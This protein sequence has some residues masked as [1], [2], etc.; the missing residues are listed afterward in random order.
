[1]S[2]QVASSVILIRPTGFGFDPQTAPSNP[3]QQHLADPEVERRAGDEFDGL[4]EALRTHGIDFVVLD[5]FDPEAP[6]GVFP[7]NWFSTHADGT[8]VL[9]PMLT[10]S[11][12][13]ERDPDL[14][15]RLQQEGFR[16][17]GTVDLS[18]WE[19]RGRILEGTGSLVLDRI[20]RKAYACISERTTETAVTDWCQRFGYTPITFVATED[21]RIPDGGGVRGLPVYHTNVVMSIG[22][23]FAV[24]CLDAMPFPAERQEVQE[25]LER[26]G[27]E[28]IP[29]AI[30]QMQHFLGN[31]L[32][33]MPTAPTART[34][35]GPGPRIFLSERAFE[36]LRPAQRLALQAHGQ[37]VPVGI[38]TIETVGGGSVRCMLAENFLPRK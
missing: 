2:Q 15:N 10:A 9:Y 28:V 7:N 31:V 35:V 20:S 30:E 19:H 5:P 36:H 38:P 34:G 21:G 14:A 16:T 17:S 33:L 12:R 6:N 25:E 37:L 13:A 3:F 8:V 23:R 1:M 18:G 11:R 29:I 24:V 4:L 32:Q 26:S 27:K 22:A